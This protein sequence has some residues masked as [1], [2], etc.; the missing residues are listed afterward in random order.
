[1]KP[2]QRIQGVLAFCIILTVILDSKTAVDSAAKGIQMCVQQV[3][4]AI[5]PILV[6]SIWLINAMESTGFSV[7]RPLGHLLRIPDHAISLLI[8]SFFGGYPVGA[9]CAV[10]QYKHG[11]LLKETTEQTLSF[12]NNAGPSFIFG[13][14]PLV[15]SNSSRIWQIWLIHIGSAVLAGAILCNTKENESHRIT[16]KNA[17]VMGTAVRAMALICGWVTL[18]RVFV[19]FLERWFL[20]RLP[21]LLSVILIG[22]LELTNGCVSLQKIPDE[23][24]RTVLCSGMLSFGGLCVHM[25]TMSILQGLSTKKYWEGKLIQTTC[26]L[27]MASTTVYA[28]VWCAVVGMGILLILILAMQKRL[29]IPKKMVYNAHRISWRKSPCYFAK[30]SSAPAAIVPMESSWKKG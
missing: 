10:E 2:R 21:P 6:L 23:A 16:M 17:P 7:L 1:M 9:Q 3:I 29:A 24:L 19:G 28:G 15:F 18:F 4:P 5:F 20:W 12:C 26:S 8:P 14:L 27:L 13:F 11:N 22:I 25:Q 30:K